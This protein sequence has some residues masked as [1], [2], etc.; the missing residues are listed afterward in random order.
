M[1]GTNAK[2]AIAKQIYFEMLNEYLREFVY[3]GET[4]EAVSDLSPGS[5]FYFDITISGFK[6]SVMKF[7]MPYFEKIF[8]FQ[9]E[10]EKYFLTVKE[11]LKRNYQN[12]SFP[13]LE[14]IRHH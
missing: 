14:G 10:D 7:T 1:G 6:D 3:L 8:N 13:I 5:H 9:P 4:A 2:E 12:H 11:K